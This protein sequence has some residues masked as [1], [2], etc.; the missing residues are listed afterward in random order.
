MKR[1]RLPLTALRSFEAAGR[2]LSFSR[3]AEE[4]FVSQAA[5]SRQI[6]ELEALI[7]QP[8][9]ARLHRRVELTDAGRSL[10]QQ[11]VA[12][13]DAIDQRLTEIQT[14]P[15]E[16]VVRVSTEP[17]FAGCWLMPRLNRFQER[18]PG[19]DVAV[20]VNTR[21][22]E[23]R[24]HEA[25]LAIRHSETRSEWPRTQA[26]HLF[27]SVAVPV[28]SPEL[29]AKGPP[30]K[31]AADLAAHTLLHEENRDG[32]ARWL[33]AARAESVKPERGPIFADG[34]FTTRA[35][36]LGHGVALGDMFMN[37]TEMKEG[38]LMQPYAVTIPFGSYWLVAPDFDALSLPARIFADWLVAEIK[39]EL[40]A[41]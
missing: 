5:I 37:A 28:I 24:T 40:E 21:L 22:T 10:L 34:S 15:R 18:C 36:A 35:A 25:D 39:A 17:F 19:I 27:D 20:D 32:W 33:K 4:L 13:F 29:A 6:R 16:G 7:R 38:S 31:S 2:H 9:F 11:L 41:L 12:S 1:G 14:R 8:L 26:R 23:F 3:A 30:L